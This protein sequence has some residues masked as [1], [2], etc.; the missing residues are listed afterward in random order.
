MDLDKFNFPRYLATLPL[1][2]SM[3]EE[4][5]RRLATGCQLRRMERGKLIFRAGEPCNEFHV[6]VLGQVKLFAISPAGVEKVIELCGPGNSFAEAVMF[7]GAPYVVSAQTLTD[8]LILTVNKDTVFSEIAQNPDFSLRMLAGLSRRLHGLIKDVEAYALHSGVQRVI[9]YLLGDRMTES[10]TASEAITV[11]LP[12]SKAS[13]A[14]R[15]SLTPEYF[16]RVLNELETA[17]LI[18]VDKRDIHIADTARLANYQ[19]R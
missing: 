18:H 5:L 15:L 19:P 9:G 8:S 16:S 10:E 13:I 14:S 3:R 11:S 6:A 4:E 17:G 1:F 7:M 12:V 2:S